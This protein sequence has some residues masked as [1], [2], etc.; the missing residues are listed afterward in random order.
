MASSVASKAA[1][2]KFRYLSA[3][4]CPFA[5]RATLAFAHHK[6]RVEYEWVEALGWELQKDHK[7]VTGTGQDWYYHWKADELKRVNASALV[8]TLISVDPHTLQPDESRVVYESLVCIDF[9]DQ[10]SGAKGKDKLVSQDPFL[11]AQ[12]RVWADKVNR[13]CCSPYYGVLVRKQSRERREHFKKLLRGLTAFSRQLERTSGPVFLPDG[14]LSNVDLALIP[15]AFRYYV[16]EH[17]RGPDYKIPLTK[18]LEPYHDWYDHVM[19]LDSVKSTLPDK[20]RYLEH[21]CK[22]ADGSARSK[23]AN[24]VRR[25]V[26]AHD[27]DDEKDDYHGK[28]EVNSTATNKR[29]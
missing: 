23:V 14:Q 11:A 27:F 20:D 4:F 5:H 8:P 7:S 28:V 12:S 9:I 3:W 21:I 17:Y 2:P 1:I 22:Y 19:N 10:I 6:G 29:S 16:L 18:V 15:W 25:G 13:D 24:A 26:A